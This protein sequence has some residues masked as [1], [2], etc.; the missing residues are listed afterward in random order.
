MNRIK[1]FEVVG[2]G[3]GLIGVLFLAHG[4]INQSTFG[5]FT[6]FLCVFAGVALGGG[7]KLYLYLKK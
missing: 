2:T 7:S 6:G 1:I 5:W 4:L 3:I